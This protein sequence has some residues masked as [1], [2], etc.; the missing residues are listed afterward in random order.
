MPPGQ[1]LLALEVELPAPVQ[2]LELQ[3]VGRFFGVCLSL[4]YTIRSF[5]GRKG[6]A[7][8]VERNLRLAPTLRIHEKDIDP[9]VEG[10]LPS[11]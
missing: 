11:F 2:S 4:H 8:A 5:F 6:A 1:P 7:E 3:A 10:E 9:T